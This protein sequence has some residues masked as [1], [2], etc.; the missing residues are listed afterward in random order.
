LGSR[1]PP[2]RIIPG[3][4]P[5]GKIPALRRKASAIYVALAFL[6]LSRVPPTRIILGGVPS[7]K[8]LR[9]DTRKRRLSRLFLC[10]PETFFLGTYH[11]TKDQWCRSLGSEGVEDSPF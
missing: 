7:G 5:F 3:R 11:K 1:F 9:S 6:L 4:R 10:G 8:S 2:S